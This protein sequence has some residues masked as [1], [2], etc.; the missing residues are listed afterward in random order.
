[1]A[2]RT[3]VASG[4]TGGARGGSAQAINLIL[5]DYKRLAET[6]RRDMKRIMQGAANIILDHTTPWVPIEYGSLR[7][8]GRAFAGR[9]D[10][11]YGAFV[12]FGGEGAPVEPSPN[13]PGGVV[14][15][16]QIVH[17]D[18][19]KYHPIGSAKF[20]EIGGKEAE[21]EVENYIVSELKKIATR[22]S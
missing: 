16:A 5:T 13:A 21:I 6:T 12:T 10:Q 9:T 2:R 18:I 4:R 15:Y 19:N 20:L 17:E 14:F 22:N 8:S 3:V 1:M 7:E 11:G